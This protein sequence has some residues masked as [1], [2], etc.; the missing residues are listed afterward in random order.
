MVTSIVIAIGYVISFLILNGASVYAIDE[1][2]RNAED[3]KEDK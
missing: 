1:V 3:N 2:M